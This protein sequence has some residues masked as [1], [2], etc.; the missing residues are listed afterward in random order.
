MH[1]LTLC[2][3]LALMA[4]GFSDARAALQP[5][6][7]SG[8]A[9]TVTNPSTGHYV[10]TVNSGTNVT[11][12]LRFDAGDVVEEIVIVPLDQTGARVRVNIDGVE[13]DDQPFYGLDS[14]NRVVRGEGAGEVWIDLVRANRIGD[15]DRDLE[16]GGNPNPNYGKASGQI[17]A[18]VIGEV[19]A[20]WSVFADI[21]ATGTALSN[22]G[23][24][25]I[26][27]VDAER[28]LDWGR[29]SRWMARSSGTSSPTAE[30]LG[31]SERRRIRSSAPSTTRR[32]TTR[33]SSTRTAGTSESSKRVRSAR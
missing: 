26:N 8:G 11:L 18:N 5:P 21:E 12:R 30:T 31:P 25:T 24:I 17:R 3:L 4:G 6:D 7:V 19:R 28:N 15:V 10:A 20:N 9:V 23:G 32:Q 22:P 1:R 13:P 29:S 2:G 16:I 33:R 14:I 27:L